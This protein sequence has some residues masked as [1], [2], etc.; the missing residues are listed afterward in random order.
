MQY[1]AVYCKSKDKSFLGS[2]IVTGDSRI[3]PF[4]EWFVLKYRITSLK[5]S[6]DILFIVYLIGL[7]MNENT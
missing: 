6:A 5:F 2:R 1:A 7:V 3:Q 4:V